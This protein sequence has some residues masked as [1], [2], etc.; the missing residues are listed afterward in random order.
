MF[1]MINFFF[2]LV[3]EGIYSLAMAVRSIAAGS[4]EER[5]KNERR[6]RDD[7]EPL[8]PSAAT[9]KKKRDAQTR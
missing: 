1:L 5:E 6:T 2:L 3:G 9:K 4:E 8:P 7:I